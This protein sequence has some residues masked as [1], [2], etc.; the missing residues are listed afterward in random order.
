MNVTTTSETL[1]VFNF[2]KEASFTIPE[3]QRNYTWTAREQVVKLFEDLWKFSKADHSIVPNYFL[4]TAILYGEGGIESMQIMDGQQRVTSMIAFYSALKSELEMYAHRSQADKREQ[5]EDY[6][7]FISEQ[8]L[9][10][11][12]EFRTSRLEPKSERDKKIIK[13]IGSLDGRDLEQHELVSEDLLKQPLAQAFCLFK[14]KLR[15]YAE[16]SEEDEPWQVLMKFGDIVGNKILITRTTTST[17][18]MAFQMFV[19]VNGPGKQ[20]I[21]FDVLKGLIIAKAHTLNIQS[22]IQAQID[23]MTS[24][25]EV[26]RDTQSSETSA[27]NKVTDCLLYWLETRIGKNTTKGDVISTLEGIIGRFTT[28]DEFNSLMSQLSSFTRHYTWFN[29]Q[30]TKEIY[31]EHALER[32]RILRLTGPSGGWKASHIGVIVAL[33]MRNW[34]SEDSQKVMQTIEWME[35]RGY[36]TQVSNR[37]EVML[38][39]IAK[40]IL[41]KEPLDT[42]LEKFIASGLKMLNKLGATFDNMRIAKL[43]QNPARAF[44][45]KITGTEL[46][47][48]STTLVAARLLPSG[49]PSPWNTKAEKEDPDSISSQ[50]GNYFLLRGIN[51]KD[52]KK[53]SL[54]NQ[55]IRTKEFQKYS[56]GGIQKTEISELVKRVA[57]KPNTFSASKVETRTNRIIRELE[58]AYP[59]DRPKFVIVKD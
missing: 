10:S 59:K 38:P 33:R 6:I 54:K 24:R 9:F 51:Q 18:S 8:V 29:W 26:L 1:T 49:S 3:I 12:E 53:L 20:L 11:D 28:S 45:H 56:I 40:L 57:S 52:A 16:I 34:D 37:L 17:I 35:F 7:E 4:G 58:L 30:K 36:F 31:A 48:N 13:M 19:S 39:Q 25:M 32:N 50:I 23:H 42:W 5:I 46:D 55:L 21:S 14:R 2:Y 44:L 43:E 41:D 27:D 47:V 15:Y 22:E